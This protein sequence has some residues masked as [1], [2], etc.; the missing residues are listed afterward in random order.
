MSA[1]SDGKSALEDC[2]VW[3]GDQRCECREERG[4]QKLLAQENYLHRLLSYYALILECYRLIEVHLGV[5]SLRPER[6]L[7]GSVRELIRNS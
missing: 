2:E 6:A 1:A 4:S 5:H 7:H 3:D